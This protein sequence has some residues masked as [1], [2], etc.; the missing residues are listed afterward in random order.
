MIKEYISKR[1]CLFID[2]KDIDIEEANRFFKS[3]NW[4]LRLN[5]HD[6]LFYLTD[7]DS[8]YG[9]AV[10]RGGIYLIKWSVGYDEVKVFERDDFKKCY[11]ECEK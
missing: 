4:R 5:S 10:I 7:L 9:E 1:K 11:K 3:R 6:D 8:P 2:T